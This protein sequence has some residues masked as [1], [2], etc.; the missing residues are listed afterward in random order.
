MMNKKY[1][2]LLIFSCIKISLVLGTDSCYRQISI[3]E[4]D[5]IMILDSIPKNVDTISAKGKRTLLLKDG[6]QLYIASKVLRKWHVWPV[7]DMI[8]NILDTI[9]IQLIQIKGIPEPLIYMHIKGQGRGSGSGQISSIK[10]LWDRRGQICYLNVMD[11]CT[12][13]WHDKYGDNATGKTYTYHYY[14][15]TFISND[16]IEIKYN[17]TCENIF[18]DNENG[19]SSSYNDVG[20]YQEGVY[21]FVDNK[22]VNQK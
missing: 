7:Q 11:A 15:T 3:F 19:Q 16:G 14:C 10:M 21:K 1:F 13:Y 22:W 9:D 2:F 18:G 6:Y 8:Y 12:Y 4:S 17:N 5:T 20:K